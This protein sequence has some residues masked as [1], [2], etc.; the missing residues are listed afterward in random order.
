M[1]KISLFLIIS[2]ILIPAVLFAQEDFDKQVEIHVNDNSKPGKLIVQH[3]KGSINVTGYD[4][5][6]VI[7]HASY[8][9][10]NTGSSSEVSTGDQIQRTNKE[11]KIDTQVDGNVVSAA[12][13]QP[14]TTIDLSIFVPRNFSLKLETYHN[15]TIKVKDVSGEMEVSNINGEIILEEVSGS[16]ILNTVDGNITAM[17]NDVTQDKPMAFTTIYGNVDLQFPAEINAIVKMKSEYGETVSDFALKLEKRRSPQSNS[18]NRRYLED[19]IYG[20]INNGGPEILIKSFDGD[21]FLRKN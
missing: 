3:I 21:I 10:K 2:V 11:I 1:V 7:I 13:N 15:G 14:G 6:L 8:R 4:G 17:F 5:V 18:L 16:A 9:L 20:R 12:T 19:W